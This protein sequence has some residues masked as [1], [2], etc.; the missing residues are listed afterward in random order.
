[1]K[2]VIDVAEM[3]GED[4]RHLHGNLYR[5]RRSRIR[6]APAG[7]AVEDGRLR[8][9]NPRWFPNKAGSSEARGLESSKME[10]LKASI[11]TSG[12]DNP[13]RLRPVDSDEP[14]LEV[15]NGER[16]FRCI[17][18]LCSSDEDCHD[19]AVG[20]SAPASEVYE[21]VDCRI[22]DLDDHGAL[23]VAL[24][25][26]ETSEVIGDLASIHVVKTLREAGFDDQDI[27]VATGKSVS[28]LRETDRII[29]LDEVCL[30]HFENDQIT[31]KAAL[32]LA[33]I[34]DAEERIA[35]LEQVVSIAQRRHSS[36]MEKL[37]RD[38]EAAETEEYVAAE[39]AKVAEDVG[40]EDADEIHRAVSKAG[41]RAGKVREERAKV[42]RKGAKADARD[43]K[44]VTGPKTAEAEV[45]LNS[46]YLE[47]I[48]SIIDQEGFDD[49]GNAYGLDLN[50]L[51]AVLG[52]IRGIVDGEEDILEI[53]KL[54]C[55]LVDEDGQVDYSDEN[56][57]E[58]VEEA[59]EDDEDDEDED[60]EEEG[61]EE[62][63]S[64]Q[65]EDRDSWDDADETPAELEKE[66]MNSSI[67][68]DEDYDD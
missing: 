26:N 25:T 1:M 45:G 4:V 22:E 13:I 29:S 8:Y 21:W 6:L 9:G 48:E 50:V 11:C 68:D 46:S 27:L 61:D 54:H 37:D 42:S 49:E 53:L 38:L 14:F 10:E 36:K 34:E 47:M 24:K 32:Q 17:E 19:A 66:F 35:V 40:D 28:W 16:R 52:V 43:V 65:E 20:D 57:D 62:R 41:K 15:V 64:L 7:L 67:Y 59:D 44:K 2:I 39:A 63:D 23:G 33:L 5:V 60:D 55:C 56:S 58:F 31:R 18:E 3:F 30:Q 51:A 12:L